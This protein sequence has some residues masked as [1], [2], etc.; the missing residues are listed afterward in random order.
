[1]MDLGSKRY[2]PEA[3]RS[4]LFWRQFEDNQWRSRL[5]LCRLIERTKSPHIVDV[6]EQFVDDGLFE[7]G[8][9]V[10]NLGRDT[11]VYRVKDGIRH[12]N[13]DWNSF[14]ETDEN[15]AN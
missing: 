4:L 14:M 5:A 1:M 12:A 9:V 6:I 3:L 15:P 7:R 2:T 11:Y 13:I 8:I 10:N